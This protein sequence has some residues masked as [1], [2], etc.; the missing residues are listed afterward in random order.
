MEWLEQKERQKK[1]VN[2][3][4]EAEGGEEARLIWARGVSAL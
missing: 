1:G 2:A 3:N 4:G